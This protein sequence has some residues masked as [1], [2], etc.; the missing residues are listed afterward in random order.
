MIR[1]VALG[2]AL[3][4]LGMTSI[5]QAATLNIDDSDPN[6][7]TISWSGFDVSDFIVS[8]EGDPTPLNIVGASGSVV[9]ADGAYNL[10][11]AWSTDEA[12]G[13]ATQ[14]V[15]FALL[16]DPTGVTSGVNASAIFLNNIATLVGTNTGGFIGSVYFSPFSPTS[17]QDAPSETVLFS[18]G[19]TDT[20]TG[21]FTSEAV[22]AVPEPAT[23]TLVGMGALG[24]I[25][26]AYRRRRQAA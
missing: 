16:S 26:G 6:T 23:A 20:L 4:A 19:G 9:L 21:S 17:P 5:G 25:V 1:R 7:M 15:W 12:N 22:V 13:N 8:I 24:L 18:L 2:L 3:A 14:A 11:G 10:D